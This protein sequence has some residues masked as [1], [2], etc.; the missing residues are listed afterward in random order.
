MVVGHKFNFTKYVFNE[1]KVLYICKKF[2]IRYIKYIDLCWSTVYIIV[3]PHKYMTISLCPRVSEKFFIKIK[4]SEP[5][6]FLP[7]ADTSF[8]IPR[9]HSPPS[10]LPREGHWVGHT[11]GGGQAGSPAWRPM[12]QAGWS[13]RWSLTA[14]RLGP[15]FWNFESVII[16]SLYE[17]S[18]RVQYQIWLKMQNYISTLFYK[19]HY[20]V[21]SK[22]TWKQNVDFFSSKFF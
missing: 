6:T 17:L 11:A 15:E 16:C 13:W 12:E 3:Y 9:P 14:G 5:G 20:A 8:P 19:K 7:L 2:C 22:C 1:N 18:F 4:L 21:T 10:P